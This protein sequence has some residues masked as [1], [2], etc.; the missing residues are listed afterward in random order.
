M[1]EVT[2]LTIAGAILIREADKQLEIIASSIVAPIS[3]SRGIQD[4]KVKLI[5]AVS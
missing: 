3:R 1:I 4:F 5:G 2:L